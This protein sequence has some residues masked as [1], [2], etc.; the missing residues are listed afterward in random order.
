MSRRE[1]FVDDDFPRSSVVRIARTR[2]WDDEEREDRSATLSRTQYRRKRPIRNRTPNSN[3][4]PEWTEFNAMVVDWT[5]QNQRDILNMFIANNGPLSV[6][7]RIKGEL[8]NIRNNNGSLEEATTRM[9]TDLFG[10]LFERLANYFLTA[11]TEG[12]RRV[13]DIGSSLKVARTLYRRTGLFFLP[14]GLII[15]THAQTPMLE[16]ICEYKT[17]P[18]DPRSKEAL[19]RQ[20]KAAVDFFS[21]VG[22][23]KLRASV[24]DKFKLDRRTGWNVEEIEISSVPSVILVIP[25][26]RQVEFLNELVAVR[27][28]PFSMYDLGVISSV[29]SKDIHQSGMIDTELKLLEEI[30]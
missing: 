12:P 6:A 13:L 29:L 27:K 15:N 28:A 3:S 20:I 11:D 18:S 9:K 10:A 30:K 5:D 14:D 2:R 8:A 19:Q 21:G 4:S 7:R 26:D 24:T 17:N 25:N 22:G 1:R 16:S 23:R